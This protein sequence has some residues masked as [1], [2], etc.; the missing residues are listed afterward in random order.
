[1]ARPTDL[2]AAAGALVGV[3]VLAGPAH[4]QATERGGEE[5]A[6]ADS[7]LAGAQ[8][9]LRVDGMSCPFCAFGLEKRLKAIAAV[10]TVVVRVSNGLV[11]IRTRDGQLL[12]DR[13]LERAV[14]R[15]GFSLR[16]VRRMERPQGSR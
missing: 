9:V 12:D 10:D 3:T 8:I 14:E 1:M 13:E 15:A 4:A 2:L 7:L 11:L 16:E 5:I 6:A